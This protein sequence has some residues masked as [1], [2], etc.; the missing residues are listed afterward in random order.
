MAIRRWLIF[1]HENGRHHLKRLLAIL[2]RGL[3][4][5]HPLASGRKQVQRS[6]SFGAT[7]ART[8]STS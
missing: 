8:F 4:K 2:T 1:I 7:S 5:R 3:I 6:A